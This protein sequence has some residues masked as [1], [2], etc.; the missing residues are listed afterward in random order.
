MQDFNMDILHNFIKEYST[1]HQPKTYLEI[2]TR[3]GDSLQQVIKHSKQLQEIFICD[4]WGSAY[5]GT[6]R[7]NHNHIDQLISDL[8]YNGNTVFLDG[9][10]TIKIK[11][12]H[13]IYDNYF[14]LI[15]VDGDHSDI[16]GYTDLKNVLQLSKKETGCI[17]FHD[18]IHPAHLSLEKVFDDFVLEHKN[19]I[20]LSEKIREHLGIGIIYT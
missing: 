10:S 7:S 2:G 4:L 1:Q 18:I 6:G 16:G 12:L 11:E 19:N 8:G 9:D 20:R 14:D 15:L 17:L 5:G 13:N 3:E